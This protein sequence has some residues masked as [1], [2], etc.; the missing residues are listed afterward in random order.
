[1]TQKRFRAAFIRGGTSK[2][3]VFRADDLPAPE[4]WP[5]IFRAAL[6]SPDPSMRQLDGMGGG[7]SS[8]SKICV[9]GP[10]SRVDADV[11]YTFAQIE[12]NGTTVDFNGNCGN[13]SSAIG[14]FAVE[15]GLVP[16]PADGT[17]VVRIHNTNTG[18]IIHARFEVCDGQAVVDGNVTIPGIAGTGA[19]VELAF[20]DPAGTR[21]HGLLPTGA[22]VDTVVLEGELSVQFTAVDAA[23]PA[24]FVLAKDMGVDIRMSPAM[25]DADTTTMARLESI[26]RAA[27]VAMGITPDLTAAAAVLSIPKI[28][29]IAPATDYAA[30]DGCRV[31]APD[32]DITIRMISTGQAHRAIPITGALALAAAATLDRGL[33]A[34]CISPGGALDHL[35]VGT[36]SGVV[37]VG[38]V[39]AAN[40][41]IRSANV[42]RTQRRLMEGAVCIRAS[43]LSI[44]TADTSNQEITE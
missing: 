23:T 26:R 41:T 12:V 27:S 1:M 16:Q 8:L 33:V 14:P 9:V 22:Q 42:V 31:A 19:G 20:M 11:D 36:P 3:V 35:R 24:V 15:E 6:G 43:A 10:S 21:G 18:K 37:T 17:T 39:L 5:A 34:Q 7:L 28:A 38:A 2:A 32:H 44:D 40:G 13:M 29:L 4:F 25:L 30:L